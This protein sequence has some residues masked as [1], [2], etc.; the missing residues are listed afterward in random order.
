MTERNNMDVVFQKLIV[1]L[2]QNICTHII[3]NNNIYRMVIFPARRYNYF[4]H[5]CTNMGAPKYI[6]QL[7][8]DVKEEIYSN[9]GRVG[10]LISHYINT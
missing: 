2:L 4:K 3:S 10:D 7:L 1:P 8:I 9:T 6:K 5:L